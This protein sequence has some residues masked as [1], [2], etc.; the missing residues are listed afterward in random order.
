MYRLHMYKYHQQ[1]EFMWRN[2]VLHSKYVQTHSQQF[3]LTLHHKPTL[4]LT[5]QLII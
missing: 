1:F 4:G 2:W 3:I 5:H